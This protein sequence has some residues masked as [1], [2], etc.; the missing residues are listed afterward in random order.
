MS[1]QKFLRSKPH[2]NIGAIILAD[3]IE[4][5][6]PDDRARFEVNPLEP[7]ASRR[8]T[9]GHTPSHSNLPGRSRAA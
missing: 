9:P 7:A 2:C 3:V 6:M 4:M 5:V 8:S 1:K